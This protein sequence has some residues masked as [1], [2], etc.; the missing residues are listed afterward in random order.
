MYSHPSSLH[1]RR[2]LG[3]EAQV[4]TKKDKYGWARYRIFD[5]FVARKHNRNT[6]VWLGT[7]RSDCRFGFLEPDSYRILKDFVFRKHNRNTSVWLGTTRSDRRLGFLKPGSYRFCFFDG[8]WATGGWPR[9]SRPVES[10]RF[11]LSQCARGSP[12]RSRSTLRNNQNPAQS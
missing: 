2:N 5:G 12:P 11:C 4:S 1:I 3:W 6:S 8:V 9:G 10:S 7:T